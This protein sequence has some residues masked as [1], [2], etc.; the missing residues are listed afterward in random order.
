MIFWI[1]EE[2]NPVLFEY[3]PE[4]SDE[5]INTMELQP[6]GAGLEIKVRYSGIFLRWDKKIAKDWIIIS[7]CYFT[8]REIPDFIGT[9]LDV[10]FNI[11]YAD[12]TGPIFNI[13]KE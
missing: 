9:E 3:E 12:S 7:R 10:I 4:M 6:Y 8:G 2:Y 5:I 11:S 1:I 13:I